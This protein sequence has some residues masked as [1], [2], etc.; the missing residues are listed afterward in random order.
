MGTHESQEQVAEPGLEHAEESPRD[1]VEDVVPAKEDPGRRRRGGPE[2][3]RLAGLEAT[4][5]EEGRDEEGA[6]GVP[7]GEGPVV[8]GDGD[9]HVLGVVRRARAADDDLDE[10]DEGEVDDEA[11]DEAGQERGDRPGRVGGGGREEEQGDGDGEPDAAVAGDLKRFEEELLGVGG[12][13]EAGVG[14]QRRARGGGRQAREREGERR[15]RGERERRVRLGR[16]GRVRVGLLTLT[17]LTWTS[18]GLSL[19]TEADLYKRSDFKNRTINQG[20]YFNSDC[21]S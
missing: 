13:M 20:V 7:A 15:V 1:D 12:V 19:L 14:G 6:G 8:G 9:V 16:G 4:A 3:E 10:A 2:E 5:G 18:S 11:R 17:G 21:L